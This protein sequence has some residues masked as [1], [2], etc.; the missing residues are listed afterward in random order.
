LIAL[1]SIAVLA[2][3]EDVR[4]FEAASALLRENP[5]AA[6]LRIEDEGPRMG[7]WSVTQPQWVVKFRRM[8]A[9]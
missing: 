9:R 6:D 1:S 7:M 5:T 8:S 2:G 3:V 4:K